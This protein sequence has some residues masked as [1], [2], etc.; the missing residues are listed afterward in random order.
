MPDTSS[1]DWETG[2]KEIVDTGG[3]K[4]KFEWVEEFE[5]S[6]DGEK[7]AAVVKTGE[8]EFNVCVNGEAWETPF[9]RIWFLRFGPD[10][11]LACIVSTE[12]EFTVAVDGQAWENTFGSVWNMRFSHDGK[13]IGVAIQQDMKYGAAVNGE[14][15]ENLYANM[16]ASIEGSYD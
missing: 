7:V 13:S 6:P 16:K 2:E 4:D 14:P 9:E 15:W 11:R 3:W 1:W 8:G 12:M 10:G 5:A